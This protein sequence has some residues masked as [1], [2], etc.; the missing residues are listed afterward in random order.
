MTVS[1][2]ARALAKGKFPKLA[3]G[4]N[5][6]LRLGEGVM[7]TGRVMNGA[8]GVGRTG[9]GLVSADRGIDGFTGDYEIGTTDEGRFAFPT[10]PPGRQYLIYTLMKDASR[11]GGVAPARKFTAGKDGDTTTVGDL[12]V[13]PALR[14]AG[15]LALANGARLPA[16]AR[17]MLGR[18]QASRTWMSRPTAAS[19]LR[20]F[21]K[22]AW[23]FLPGSMVSGFP[24]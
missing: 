16:G 14:I 17:V 19:Y 8:I 20:E 4:T 9:V 11:N 24:F 5:H 15:C 1:V 6:L 7:V 23:Q 12:V 22:R 3:S 13:E 10:I 21:R 2:E 18:E